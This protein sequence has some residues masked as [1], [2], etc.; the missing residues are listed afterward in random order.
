[1][2]S[3]ADGSVIIQTSSETVAAPPSLYV[4]IS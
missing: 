2:P 1:M 3:I 4:K